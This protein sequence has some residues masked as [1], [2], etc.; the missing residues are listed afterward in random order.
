[1]GRIHP[2]LLPRIL[3]MVRHMASFHHLQ[4][5]H[6]LA[7]RRSHLWRFGAHIGHLATGI[8]IVDYR[9]GG[10]ISLK[11]A[12]IRTIPELS[13]EFFV[14]AIINIILIFT[15]EDHRHSFDLFAGTIAITSRD[16]E[17]SEASYHDED[18]NQEMAKMP[19]TATDP[20]LYRESD[21]P[22]F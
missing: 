14:T 1:M 7:L 3:G 12:S 10:P 11:Q 13:Y 16:P 21:R 22:P 2:I 4:D 6:A 20:I 5:S 8:R 19:K 9:T 15:R 17:P 18:Q